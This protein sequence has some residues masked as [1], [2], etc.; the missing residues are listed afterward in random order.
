MTGVQTCALPISQTPNPKPQTPNPKPQTPY[1]YTV[2]SNKLSG[3]VRVEGMQVAMRY[4]AAVIDRVLT[5]TTSYIDR[6][7]DRRM[8]LICRHA[9]ESN[10]SSLVLP[11]NDGYSDMVKE[12]KIVWGSDVLVEEGVADRGG[13]LGNRRQGELH[14]VRLKKID[15]RTLL[16][17]RTDE[18][19][20]LKE[21]ERTS[22]D[23]SYNELMK[24]LKGNRHK[25]AQRRNYDR[26]TE[27][28]L[29]DAR[30]RFRIKSRPWFI[31]NS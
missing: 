23:N 26:S 25:P 18:M 21:L 5:R 10:S 30:C 8:P 12:S 14:K 20:Y 17:K 2:M 16:R 22:V 9:S 1:T 31:Y 27:I 7:V 15:C 24:Y 29:K 4:N 13:N 3:R 19:T 6:I 28:T 11:D